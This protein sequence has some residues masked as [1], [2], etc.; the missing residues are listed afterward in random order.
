MTELIHYNHVGLQLGYGVP[1]FRKAFYRFR[2]ERMEFY[3][4]YEKQFPFD[5]YEEAGFA[6]SFHST[7]NPPV[8]FVS[9][10]K[11]DDDVMRNSNG[12]AYM[13][14]MFDLKRHT[15]TYKVREHPDNKLLYSSNA[16]TEKPYL[17]F[18]LGSG[19]ERLTS[20][21]R[22]DFN[23]RLVYY[24]LPQDYHYFKE[25]FPFYVDFEPTSS[26]SLFL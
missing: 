11:M 15:F 23:R 1:G 7:K 10:P 16:D 13:V 18:Q 20:R 21:R 4:Q 6:D 17:G 5:T 9:S 12:F 22:N 8:F 19:N 2:R 26:P 24:L 25:F 3:T 14:T